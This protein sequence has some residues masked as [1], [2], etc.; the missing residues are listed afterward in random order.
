M[1]A[2]SFKMK[3]AEL[4]AILYKKVVSLYLLFLLICL[5]VSGKTTVQPL[6]SCQYDKVFFQENHQ[7]GQTFAS[8]S[9]AAARLAEN[10]DEVLKVRVV[11][12][13]VYSTPDQNIS[14][15][16]VYSQL[17]VL[18]RDYRRKN[19]DTTQTLAIFKPIAAD[20]RIEFYL[21]KED[22]QGNPTS[23]ITRTATTHGPFGNA[24]IHATAKGGKTPWN[25][26]TF[27]N[28]WIC[29]LAPS[30][31]G[32]GTAPGTPPDRDGV[33][34]QY[35]QVGTLGTVIAPYT[36]GRTVT[37]EIGHWLGLKH[38]WGLVGGCQDDDGIADTPPQESASGGCQLE[39]VSCGGRNMVQ[40]Y[41]DYS[42]D[43]CLNLFT[44]GQKFLMRQTIRQVRANVLDPNA[45]P[46]V[47][48]NKKE[49]K[50]PVVD[51]F[52]NPSPDGHF[53]I[54]RGPMRMPLRW[55]VSDAL[56]RILVEGEL[57]AGEEEQLL[58]VNSFPGGG[59]FFLASLGSQIFYQRIFF[60]HKK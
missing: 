49:L 38:L 25:S 48:G 41:M 50:H 18:N 58:D 46:I 43:A 22:E 23:G 40:N 26:D 5:F 52:P 2:R 28:I 10:E 31:L 19:A 21:A 53:Y 1:T 12:H 55:W 4:D 30:A 34:V 39:R 56:G 32:Y 47:L 8:N 35:Q 44:E 42:D 59:Y 37:H 17:D 29:N 6:R 57:L 24:D 27:L 7:Q 20:P 3:S 13:V 14:D 36:K 16:Q 45:S 60:T 33:V 15:A 51:I 54:R 11:V 9:L